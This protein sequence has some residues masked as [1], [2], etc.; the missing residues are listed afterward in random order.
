MSFARPAD[1]SMESSALS[2]VSRFKDRLSKGPQ[3]IYADITTLCNIRCNYCF[4]YSPLIKNNHFKKQHLSLLD[5]RQVLDQASRWRVERFSIPGKGE[6]TC[7]PD[8][9]KIAALLT[10]MPFKTHISTNAAFPAELCRSLSRFD[11]VSA[12]LSAG[13]ASMYRSIHSKTRGLFENVTSNIRILNGLRKKAGFS[14]VHIICVVQ[15]ENYRALGPFLDLAQSLGSSLVSFR[16][17]QPTRWTKNLLLSQAQ[18]RELL[19]LISGI[20]KSRQGI[21]H[22]LRLFRERILKR[23]GQGRSQKYCLTGWS[24]LFIN[25]NGDVGICCHNSNLV[26]GHLGDGSLKE[27]WEGPQARKLRQACLL[28]FD[29]RRF[30][31]KGN[32]EWCQPSH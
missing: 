23:G 4:H 14:P 28:H 6:P 8:F 13:D 30:P 20:L 10:A 32:C 29:P 21:S 11:S 2:R 7:H 27:I 12:T 9:L 18:N 26:I 17:M 25:T 19:K 31:F 1:L 22:N 24:N 16:V 5:I 15:K 3:T